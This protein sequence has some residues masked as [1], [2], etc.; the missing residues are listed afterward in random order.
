VGKL[1]DAKIH[2]AEKLEVFALEREWLAQLVA[3][4]PWR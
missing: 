1:E 3:R 4:R 2:R